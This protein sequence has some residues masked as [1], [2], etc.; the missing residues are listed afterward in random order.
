MNVARFETER[1]VYTTFDWIHPSARWD[2]VVSSEC[3][4]TISS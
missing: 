2:T 1:R 3:A 4:V